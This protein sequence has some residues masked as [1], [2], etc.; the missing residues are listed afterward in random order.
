MTYDT[1]Y[2]SSLYYFISIQKF[3]IISPGA[4]YK[5]GSTTQNSRDGDTVIV[6]KDLKKQM[7]FLSS[8]LALRYVV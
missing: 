2:H 3:E 4:F 8:L 7:C 5:V 6:L 1:G